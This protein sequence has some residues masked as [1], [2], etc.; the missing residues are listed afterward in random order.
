M[1]KI[2]FKDILEFTNSA[3]TLKQHL[4]VGLHVLSHLQ[5]YY[6]LTFPV[7]GRNVLMYR[8]KPR[9]APTT[10]TCTYNCWSLWTL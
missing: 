2:K 5:R 7:I 10:Q 9:L 3:G 8:L 4:V 6:T 1:N